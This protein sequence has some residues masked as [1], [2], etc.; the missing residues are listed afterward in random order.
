MV[1]SIAEVKSGALVGEREQVARVRELVRSGAVDVVVCHATDR[2]SRNQAHLYILAEEFENAGVRL[3]F[4]TEPFEDTAVGK[5]LRSAKAFAGEVEREKFR[6][7]SRRGRRARVQSG[8]LIHGKTPMYRYSWDDDESKA[9]YVRNPIA[10]PVVERMFAEL[11]AGSTTREVAVG[12]TREGISPPRSGRVWDPTTVGHILREA[13]Y[14]GEAYAF[15]IRHWKKGDKNFHE[16]RPR[17]EWLA[18][19]EGTIPPLIDRATFDAVQARLAFNQKAASRNLA[20]PE[21]YL[22]RGGYIRYGYCTNSLAGV[23]KKVRGK[24]NPTYVCPHGDRGA[25][26]CRPHGISVRLIDQIVWKQAELILTRPEIIAAE[27]ERLR[28]DDPTKDDLSAVGRSLAKIT[29]EQD[30]ISRRIGQIDDDDAAAPLLA[31]LASLAKQK[32]QAEA[33]RETIRGRRAGWEMAPSRLHEIKS[34]CGD[35]AAR[36]G[37]L[38]YQQKRLALDALGVQVTLWRTDHSPR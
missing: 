5:F 23:A 25:V 6:E 18:L 27:L 3:E 20:S 33:E 36:L 14:A 22:L 34:W 7:R 17:E 11:L 15:R 12:L 13:R 29:R 4:V 30:N 2:L 1:D 10:A 16:I 32:R 35:V 19:P 24:V 38:T 8:K 9:R 31:Q 26:R 28:Q 21:S 37:T